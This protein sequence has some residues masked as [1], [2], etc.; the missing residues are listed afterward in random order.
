MKLTHLLPFLGMLAIAACGGDSNDTSSKCKDSC[1]DVCDGQAA[2]TAA[3]ITN[4]KTQCDELQARADKS[5]CD[6][7]LSKLFDCSALHGCDAD[8]VSQC[9]SQS[10]AVDDCYDLYCRSNTSDPEC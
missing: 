4:C 2:P 10:E 7:Q 3:D 6:S 5:G 9:S 8:F 1:D